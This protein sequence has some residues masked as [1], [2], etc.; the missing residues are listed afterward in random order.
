VIVVRYTDDIVAG[1]EPRA[2]AEHFLLEWKERLQGR[3]KLHPDK[4]LPPAA[5]P[6]VRGDNY[7]ITGTGGVQGQRPV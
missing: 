3:L 4:T 2:E 6:W 7:S 5:L 1:F